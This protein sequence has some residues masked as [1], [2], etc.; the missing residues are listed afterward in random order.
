MNRVRQIVA[1]ALIGLSLAAPTTATTSADSLSVTRAPFR[2]T[3]LLSGKITSASGDVF[4][5]P[6][7]PSWRLA[8]K[9]LE[10]EGAA[11]KPGDPVVRF[12][13]GTLQTDITSAE[14]DLN[15][16]LQDDALKDAEARAK[17]LDLKLAL[18]KAKIEL[19]KTTIDAN[20]SADVRPARE[21]EDKQLAFA[22]AKSAEEAA[23]RALATH[24]ATAISDNKQREIDI[25]VVQE[26]LDRAQRALD[27]MELRATRVGVFVYGTNPQTDRKVQVGDTVFVGWPVAT[28]PDPGSLEIEAFAGEAEAS[29]LQAGQTANLILDAYPQTPMRGVVKRVAGSSEPVKDWGKSA[30]YRVILAFDKLDSEMLRPGMSVRCEVVV[31]ELADALLVPLSAVGRDKDGLFVSVAGTHKPIK[32]LALD[33]FHAVVDPAAGL[34]NGDVLDFVPSGEL[35]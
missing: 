32:P 9:W 34:S 17:A 11:V 35:Q 25:Q 19:Q 8:I 7:T 21:Y 24:E 26:K 23:R 33:S 5:V 29:F 27:S 18:E 31:Q 30:Y 4:V 1:C 20:V 12:D 10:V 2:K 6:Q 22:K 16:K 13:T 15:E 28:V 3:L 14:I